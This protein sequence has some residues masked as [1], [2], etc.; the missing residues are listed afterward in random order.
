MGMVVT[1]RTLARLETFFLQIAFWVSLVL[2]GLA[3]SLTVSG[4]FS[5]LSYLVEQRTKEIGLGWRSVPPHR[6]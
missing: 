4:L 6:R 2:G 1:M 3:L 5:V